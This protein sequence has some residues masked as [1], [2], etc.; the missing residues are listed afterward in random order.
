M[1]RRPSSFSN[2]RAKAPIPTKEFELKDNADKGPLLLSPVVL[3]FDLA[4]DLLFLAF[5]ANVDTS[6]G[7]QTFL[8]F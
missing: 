6:I 3:E 2:A 4:V 1:K 5:L 8:V 7:C